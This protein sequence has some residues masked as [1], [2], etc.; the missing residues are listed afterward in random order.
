MFQDISWSNLRESQLITS[1]YLS[2]L[3]TSLQSNLRK[4]YIYLC[5]LIIL[6]MATSMRHQYPTTSLHSTT[7]ALQDPSPLTRKAFHSQPSFRALLRSQFYIPLHDL[8]NQSCASRFQPSSSVFHGAL[9]ATR[10]L[11]VSRHPPHR[12]LSHHISRVARYP[13]H[14]GWLKHLIAGLAHPQHLCDIRSLL[15]YD[16]RLA[17]IAGACRRFRGRRLSGAPPQDVPF[18]IVK[19]CGNLWTVSA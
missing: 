9:D 4:T 19:P 3:T 14:L 8:T 12:H 13:A 18:L 16:R 5:S 11:L 1:I 2:C 17:L 15:L 10:S 7:L 6:L